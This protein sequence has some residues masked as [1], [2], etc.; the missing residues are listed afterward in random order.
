MDLV[1][2]AAANEVTVAEAEEMLSA[3]F[4]PRRVSL[5]NSVLY[6]AGYNGNVGRGRP[7]QRVGAA[8]RVPAAWRSPH[9]QH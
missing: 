7:G 5:R 2:W 4:K 1:T 9:E 3:V 6:G 8:R